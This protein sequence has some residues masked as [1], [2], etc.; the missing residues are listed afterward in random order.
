MAR[1]R[2]VLLAFG[3]VAASAEALKVIE[4]S[5]GP[6]KYAVD[7]GQRG[8]RK[9][10]EYG[11]SLG[12]RP[13]EGVIEE[14][15]PASWDWRNKD[16]RNYLSPVRNQHIPVYCGSC[17]AFASTSSLADRANIARG[18][19]WPMAVLSPQ[20]VIDCGGAG[21]CDGGDDKLVYRYAFKHGVPIDTCNQYVAHN[22]ACNRK[23]QCYTCE[24]SGK[25]LPVY[26]Y[27][28]LVVGE[29]GTLSGRLE[30][31]AEIM[32]RG[33]I[34]CSI[35]ATDELD[36]YKGGVFA[37]RLKE[38]SPNHVISVVGWTVIDGTEVWI[39]RNSWGEPWGEGGFYN[40]PT[41]RDPR[42]AELNLGIE[43]DCA[44]GAVDRWAKASELGF[45]K[46]PEDDGEPSEVAPRVAAS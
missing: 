45:P 16:G 23:H 46:G 12:P 26:D 28:R 38:P 24:P 32:K 8:E 10:S 31:K 14:D 20:A 42:N 19:A 41:S 6:S 15:L 3:L 33:P 29:H 43:L 4:G 21:S 9:G 11:L 5:K 39:T 2:L 27:N 17:W 36:A 40:S 18:G 37:Q 7:L 34:S 44:F 30:M 25:C 22:Q 13:H 35:D 1:F